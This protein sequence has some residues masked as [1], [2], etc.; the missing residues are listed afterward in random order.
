MQI[1]LQE[2]IFWI[3]VQLKSWK[4]LLFQFTIFDIYSWH[5]I[6]AWIRP[7]LKIICVKAVI[8]LFWV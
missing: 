5:K 3:Q 2:S 7:Y 4:L 8:E 6:F 1:I